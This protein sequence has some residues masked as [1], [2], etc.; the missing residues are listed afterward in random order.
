[1]SV[2]KCKHFKIQELVCNHVMQHYSEEQIWSFLDEDLKKTLDIIRERLNLPL[3]I[4][5]PKMG[6]F[7]R[8]L[9]C[10]LC[11]LVKNNK[12][13]YISAHIQGKAVDILLPANCGITAEDA[14]HKIEGFADE[15]PCNI[16]FEH[17]QK[18]IPISWVHIDV[19][20]NADNKKVYWFDV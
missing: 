13:P 16:R 11:D 17:R 7:Q 10:H 9:R 2:Y 18:G 6:T 3:T 19:R 1:M 12:S 20:D 8:G 14:R 4:N 15:L 5:Q